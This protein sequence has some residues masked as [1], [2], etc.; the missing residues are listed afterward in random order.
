M[1]D[2]S[3]VDVFVAAVEAGGFAAAGERLHLTRSAVA[4]AIARIEERLDVRLFHRTT[5][6]LGLTEDGQTYYERCVRLS[7]Q[8]LPVAY[9]STTRKRLPMQRRL[10]TVSLGCPTG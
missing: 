2:L 4:K 6:T 10:V 5:R 8:R 9:G 3:G 1:A 7:R